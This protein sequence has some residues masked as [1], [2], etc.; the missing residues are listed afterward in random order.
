MQKAIINQL[1]SNALV[2]I[3]GDHTLSPYYA[4]E[5]YPAIYDAVASASKSVYND[6]NLELPNDFSNAEEDVAPTLMVEAFHAICDSI[7][8][9]LDNHFV[10][11]TQLD[12]CEPYAQVIEA[13]S[14]SEAAE[15]WEADMLCEETVSKKIFS[16]RSMSEFIKTP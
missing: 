4:K 14:Q 1:K 12:D 8:H 10:L 13:S 16:N 2:L 5:E 3:Y 11:S 9:V 7:T 6:R 15:Q